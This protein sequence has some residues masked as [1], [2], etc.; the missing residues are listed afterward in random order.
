MDDGLSDLANISQLIG[1]LTH[2][3]VVQLQE[4]SVVVPIQSVTVRIVS[5]LVSLSNH[6]TFAT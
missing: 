6:V 4:M 1:Y 3:H 2:D 5:I